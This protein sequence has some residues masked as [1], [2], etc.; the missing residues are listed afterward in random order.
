MESG[1][2]RNFFWEK[3]ALLLPINKRTLFDVAFQNNNV[4]NI[5]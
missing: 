3:N 1:C 5:T 4:N 2:S